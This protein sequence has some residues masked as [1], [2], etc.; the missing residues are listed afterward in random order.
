MCVCVSL[1]LSLSLSPPHGVEVLGQGVKGSRGVVSAPKRLRWRVNSWKIGRDY[2][3]VVLMMI[4]HV[5][6]PF[7]VSGS[8]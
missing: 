1:S 2:G 5:E 4:L 8:L 3:D 6:E 7:C